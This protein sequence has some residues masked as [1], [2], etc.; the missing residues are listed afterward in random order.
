MHRAVEELSMDEYSKCKRP[1]ADVHKEESLCGQ[2]QEG[3]Q[4]EL[5]FQSLEPSRTF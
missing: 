4:Q 5:S 3:E 2:E 1:E